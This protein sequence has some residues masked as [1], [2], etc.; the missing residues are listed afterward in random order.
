[1][2]AYLAGFLTASAVAVLA[3]WLVVYPTCRESYVAV[4]RNNGMIEARYELLKIVREHLGQDFSPAEPHEIVVSVKA[5]AIAVVDRNGVK[6]L[7]VYE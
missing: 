1:M 6:T 2:K 4:G 3:F 7:R 5:E